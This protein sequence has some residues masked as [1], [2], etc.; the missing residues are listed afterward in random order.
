MLCLASLRFSESYSLALWL[1]GSLARWLVGSLARF[2]GSGVAL[3]WIARVRDQKDASPAHGQCV[4]V[5]GGAAPSLPLR[6]ADVVVHEL[7]DLARGAGEVSG[8]RE[9]EACRE[10]CIRGVNA[11]SVRERYE[12]EV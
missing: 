8:R 12:W 2:I 3:V 11:G 5:V 6:R 1:C 4:G 10:A 7:L 9:W